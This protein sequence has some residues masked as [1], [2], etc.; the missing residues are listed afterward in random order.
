MYRIKVYLE[1]LG[2]GRPL[3]AWTD[4]ETWNGWAVPYFE[5]GAALDLVTLYNQQHGLRP[6]GAWYDAVADVFCFV[7]D[8]AAEPEC[9]GPIPIPG[10]GPA[11]KLY[12]IGARA[13]IWDVWGETDGRPRAMS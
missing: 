1:S 12:P 3:D 7:L 4:G 8:G 5:Y 6:P 13:W 10:A 11:A 2:I 9:F